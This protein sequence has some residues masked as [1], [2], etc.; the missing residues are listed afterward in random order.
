M[1]H[2]DKER[3]Q[4]YLD[5]ALIEEE[6]AQ[7]E[8]HLAQ[9]AF[10]V[11]E[12]KVW[13]AVFAPLSALPRLEP[14][15]TFE[16]GVLAKLGI[17]P[18]WAKLFARPLW[19]K[20]ALTGAMATVAAWLA[21]LSRYLPDVNSP[22]NIALITLP[23]KVSRGASGAFFSLVHS[24]TTIPS[25]IRDIEFY[26]KIGSAAF[27]AVN[28]PAV[29]GSLFLLMTLSLYVFRAA[30]THSLGIT[31]RNYHGNLTTILL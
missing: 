5:G 3:I 12:L 9:C 20:V 4:H 6:R 10:C 8:K 11:Q 27:S 29:W 25:L 28:Q 19:P 7:V 18:W 24:L 30:S 14:S 26:L 31:R 2:L 17:Q 13:E 16:S 15:R 22:K 21:I 23:A 1:E